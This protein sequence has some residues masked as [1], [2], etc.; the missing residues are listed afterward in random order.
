MLNSV[1]PDWLMV[2][3]W[4]VLTFWAAILLGAF[5]QVA[6]GL[7]AYLGKALGL[8]LAGWALL[9]MVGMAMGTYSVLQPLGGP[10]G[11]GIAANGG[12][13]RVGAVPDVKSQFVKVRS[14][15]ELDAILAG[16]NRPVLLDFYAD[17]CVSCIEM[18]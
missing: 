14:V 2:L 4:I 16:A 1:L 3:G 6:S 10:G 9:M 13:A 17:W 8:L 12:T 7:L 18:E 15:Q 11:A 5:R